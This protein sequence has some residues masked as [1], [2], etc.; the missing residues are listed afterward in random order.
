MNYA[1]AFACVL[2][3]AIY[4]QCMKLYDAKHAKA[5]NRWHLAAFV[6]S[7][8]SL[9]LALRSPLERLADASFFYHMAQHMVLVYVAAPL[10]LLSAPMMLLLGACKP[11]YARR[12]ARLLRS[13]AWRIMTFP[14]FAWLFFTAVLWG[15]HL[16]GLY[17]AALERP[18]SHLLEHALFFGSALLFWQSIIHI[19]PVAWPMNFPLRIVY[20][21]T[22][23]PQSAFLGLALYQTRHVL[24]PHYVRTQGSV[25]AALSDQHNGGA[26]MWIAGGLLLFT[27]FML[28]AASW[29]YHERR[30]GEV[31]DVQ[32]ERFR[33]AALTVGIAGLL[34]A[35]AVMPVS[36]ASG[37]TAGRMLY[38]IHCSACHA[39][40][41]QGTARG[42]SLRAESR[43]GVD[44]WLSTGR[45]PA[46][47]P[48]IQ[49][50]HKRSILGPRQIKELTDFV[51]S[52]SGGSNTLPSVEDS[53]D[54]AHGRAL[55]MANC[56][57][58]HGATASGGAVGYGWI[59][60]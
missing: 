30:L 19:G 53:G 46:S 36:A 23:M 17:E 43:A 26:L 16:S 37:I 8:L 18:G 60:P 9:L 57:A 7:V 29:G 45:M 10:V 58:C 13:P 14:V 33:S 22:A 56:A 49:D 1:L 35:A 31:L 27:V 3:I 51:M 40:S 4:A 47:V 48:Y 6:A 34:F 24:Y 42:P 59:A 54:L 55:F 32:S 39:A 2:A 5:F 38:T 11:A 28:V 21:F 44:F 25:A 20:V 41:L 52:R 12:T 15:T 50:V